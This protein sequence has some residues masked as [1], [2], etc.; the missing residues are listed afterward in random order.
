MNKNSKLKNIFLETSKSDLYINYNIRSQFVDLEKSKKYI[1]KKFNINNKKILDIGCGTGSMYSALN[2]K[3]NIDYTGIDLDKKCILHAKKK[4][5]NKAKFYPYN[6]FDK[7]IKKNSYDVVMIW[8]LFYMLPDW[9]NF[10]IRAAEV[11][12]KWIMFDNKIKFQGNTIVDKDLSYQYYHLSNRRNHYIIHNL[13][14]LISFF[15]I[16]ELN[17]DSVFGYGYKM[18]GK[19]SARLPIS[20]KDVYVGTFV[21]NKSKKKTIRTGV[22][23]DAKNETWTKFKINFPGFKI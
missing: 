23:L 1:F 3:F 22:R 14:E 13:N 15:Q 7:R 11:S 18:P 4:Y 8:N 5:K 12:K 10:L 21:L 9:K 16:H 19:T 20:K 6:I 2:E 17:L